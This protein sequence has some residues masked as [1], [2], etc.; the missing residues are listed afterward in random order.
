MPMMDSET[1]NILLGDDQ[2]ARLLTFEAILEP[3]RQ[4]LVKARSGEAALKYLLD[5]EF[6]AILLD[7]SM[8]GMN[9]F[10]T[11]D[12]IRQHPRFQQM[13]IIFV[14]G[15]HVTDLDRLRGYRMGAVDYVHVPVV[16]EI[17]R[18]KLQVLVQLHRQRCQL[19]ALN[20]SLAASNAAL[21]QAH[22][23]LR[24]EK[25]RE[26]ERANE[27]LRKEIRE[28]ERAQ[29]ALHEAARRKDQFLAILA[30]ELRNPL[31]AIHNGVQVLRASGAE[32]ARS[33]RVHELLERQV[34]HLTRLIED[35]LDVSRITSGRI[36]LKKEPCEL[37]QIVERGLETARR[38]IEERRHRLKL[39][40]PRAPVYV[41]GDA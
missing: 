20:R 37:G 4:N 34:G 31:S 17:L 13:P 14:T 10:E 38:L 2:P 35:L 26:L 5:M 8:P 15:V 40:L 24:A 16:P 6:A 22:S 36:R 29:R 41:E 27:A 11:A 7:V 1:A 32:D 30:H 3:L 33:R 12:L 19:R 9:G 23:S 25:T 18:S 21:T 28:R 39:E